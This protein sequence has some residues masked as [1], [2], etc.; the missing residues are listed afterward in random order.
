M[1]L[2]ITKTGDLEPMV[3]LQDTKMST[4]FECFQEAVSYSY[5]ESTYRLCQKSENLVY[6]K[7]IETDGK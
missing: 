7:L 3:V 5:D 4:N 6:F 2:Q 1:Q